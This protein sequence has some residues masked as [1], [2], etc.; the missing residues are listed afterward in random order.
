MISWWLHVPA[1]I[2]SWLSSRMHKINKNLKSYFFFSTMPCFSMCPYTLTHW[3]EYVHLFEINT[4]WMGGVLKSFSR[5]FTY[6]TTPTCM[7]I[8]LNRKMPCLWIQYV[9]SRTTG[10]NIACLYPFSLVHFVNADSK[11][12]HENDKFLMI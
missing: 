10:R 3:R 7:R 2:V 11:Y 12:G 6:L 4:E 8:M 5:L 1:H 9:T